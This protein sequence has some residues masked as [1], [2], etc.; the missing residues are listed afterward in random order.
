M[1]KYELDAEG[2]REKVVGV[3]K[4]EDII[5]KLSSQVIDAIF[6]TMMINLEK[7]TEDREKMSLL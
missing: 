5:S 2:K 1:L 3:L 6:A 7:I 4:H